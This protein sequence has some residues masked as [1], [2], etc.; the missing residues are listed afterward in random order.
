[1]RKTLLVVLFLLSDCRSSRTA[2]YPNELE[3]GAG[4]PMRFAAAGGFTMGSNDGPA[5]AIPAHMVQLAACYIDKY[6]VTNAAY[7]PCVEAGV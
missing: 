2:T 4:L 1:M 6:E 5:D 3:D 7:A